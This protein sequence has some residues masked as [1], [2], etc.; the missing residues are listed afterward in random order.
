MNTN[1]TL[2][3]KFSSVCKNWEKRVQMSGALIFH[4]VF[5][6]FFSGRKKGGGDISQYA[7]MCD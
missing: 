4:Q 5:S 1:S 6:L 2:D 3:Q 7:K